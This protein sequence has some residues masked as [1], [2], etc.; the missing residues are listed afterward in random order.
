MSELK[1]PLVEGVIN[2]TEIDII[3]IIKPQKHDRNT[4]GTKGF[5][6]RWI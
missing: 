3:R 6:L 2:K 5:K 1:E 4:L